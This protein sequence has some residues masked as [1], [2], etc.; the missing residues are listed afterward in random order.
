L[1]NIRN[2]DQFKQIMA[3]MK[4]QVDEMRQRVDEMKKNDRRNGIVELC[5]I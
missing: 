4:E 5:K 3:Q 1:E 2:D